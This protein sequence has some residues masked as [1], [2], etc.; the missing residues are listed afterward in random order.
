MPSDTQKAQKGQRKKA[1]KP[2]G[3]AIFPRPPSNRLHQTS[4]ASP[5]QGKTRKPPADTPGSS[6]RARGDRNETLTLRAGKGCEAAPLSNRPKARFGLRVFRIHL[7][8][9]YSF[10]HKFVL[11]SDAQRPSNYS[12][13]SEDCL[14]REE[15]CLWNDVSRSLSLCLSKVL[16]LLNGSGPIE[17]SPNLG[18]GNLSAS[19]HASLSAT[20]LIAE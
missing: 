7:H 18:F 6:G 9:N 4:Q 16:L 13:T 2:R 17:W 11:I 1:R 19:Q 8:C 3:K 5:A 12:G 15:W 20:R 10:L 14:Y